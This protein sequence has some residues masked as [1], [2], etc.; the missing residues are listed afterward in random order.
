MMMSPGALLDIF[1][2]ITVSLHEPQVQLIVGNKLIDFLVD[3]GAIYSVLNIKVT[4]ESS[5]SVMVTGVTVQ[6][7]NQAFLLCDQKI[8]HSFLYMPD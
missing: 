4:K 2:H 7:Q 8:V 3:M 1:Q 6:L 5:D